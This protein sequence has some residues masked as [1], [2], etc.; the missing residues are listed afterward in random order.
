MWTERRAS[1][2]V[3]Q[4]KLEKVEA[5]LQNSEEESDKLEEAK[6]VWEKKLWNS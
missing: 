1:K 6:E 3:L 2:G 4:R 5:K